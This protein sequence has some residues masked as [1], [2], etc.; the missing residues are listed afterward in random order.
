MTTATLRDR[1]VVTVS[2]DDARGFLQGLV[3]NDVAGAL[4]VWA[5]LLSPQ[6]KRLF[7]FLVWGDASGSADTLHLD[8]AESEADALVQ[9][10]TLYR[11]RR[12]LTIRRNPDLQVVW[13]ETIGEGLAP[14]PR[15]DALGNRGVMN[16]GHAN[17]DDASSRYRAIRL[18]AGV[19][20]GPDE[21]GNNR[22]LWLECN[23]VELNG[24][25]FT[26]GCYVGQENTA[27]MNWRNKVNRRVVVVPVHESDP[28]RQLMVY[29]ELGWAVDH[30]PVADLAGLALPTW[31]TAPLHAEDAGTD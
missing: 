3:T 31:L 8:V 28:A 6:G 13:S 15:L 22:L 14:D 9:R 18:A 7:D 12:P 20:E 26:K 25:S 5:G 11:L 16:A 24:V 4:P 19:V 1:A 30:R 17:P 21:L 10:L 29:R 23:A 27:R 2:G